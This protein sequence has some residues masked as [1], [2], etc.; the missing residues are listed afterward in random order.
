M[1]AKFTLHATG[2]VVTAELKEI[3]NTEHIYY[4]KEGEFLGGKEDSKKIYLTTQ[5][6]Y[7][8]AKEKSEW[9]LI[10]LEKHIG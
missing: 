3:D 5:T 6:E 4:T 9:K 10:N 8:K 2:Q 7:D 1:I